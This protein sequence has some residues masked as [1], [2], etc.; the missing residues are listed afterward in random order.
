[1]H[2]AFRT[3]RKLPGLHWTPENEFS[4][5][6]WNLTRYADVLYCSRHPELFSSERGIVTFEPK[7]PAE[8]TAASNG[9]GKMLIT[10]D[11]PRHV[12]VRRLI[13]KGFTP[14][15]VAGWEPHVRKITNELLDGFGATRGG[16]F[17]LE[18]AS[19]LPLAVICEMMGLKREDW[20][21][22]FKLTNK[23]LGPGDPEYQ[24]DVPEDQRGTNEAARITGNMGTMAMFGFFAQ[25]LQQ[26]QAERR[27]DLISVLIDSEVEDE[28]LTD[29][30]VLWFAFLLILAGNETTRN[31]I[32]GGLLAL[33]EHP[34]EKAR[35]LKDMSLLPS[36]VEEILRWVSPVTH[37]SRVATQDCDINGHPI[38]QGERV[39]MWYPSVNRDPAMFADPETFNITRTPNDHLAFG[40]GEHFCLG[41]GFA[42]LEMRVMYEEL[43]KRF[44]G[45]ELA[46]PPERLMS[47]FIGGIKHLPVALNN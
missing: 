36:A 28:R 32:T 44:P 6:Y 19:Q 47:T 7:D 46:G 41:S 18:V 13:N 5:G 38:K 35:L 14:R 12:K 42:K 11:P 26:R 27:D 23:V 1:M 25:I 29:D 17:V 31:G 16:D 43:F 24:E 21:Y 45:V 34:E 33:C 40:I 39:T 8:A 37:M 20:P 9:N 15:A 3:L 22:M 2:E 4:K 30:D 10:M